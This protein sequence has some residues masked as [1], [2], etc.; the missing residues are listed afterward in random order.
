LDHERREPFGS[1]TAR[2][3]WITNGANRL[4][5]ERRERRRTARTVWITNGANRLERERRERRRTARTVWITNGA[6][7]GERRE[8]ERVIPISRRFAAF[9]AVRDPDGS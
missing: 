2:T 9:R 7:V 4:D 3:V 5:H 6:N 8:R 1:R